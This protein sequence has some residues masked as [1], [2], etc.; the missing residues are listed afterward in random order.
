MTTSALVFAF[1]VLVMVSYL[2]LVPLLTSPQATARKKNSNAQDVDVEELETQYRRLLASIHDL[3][4]DYD[5]GKVTDD[6]YAEQRKFLLGRSVSALRQLDSARSEITDI[7][8]DI[9]ATI[10]AKRTRTKKSSPKSKKDRA[11]EKKI[12]ARRRQKVS[13]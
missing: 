2:G 1:V 11:L 9:E 5:T 6:V 10:A 8:N 4:F 3:D 12:A 7:E 13:S